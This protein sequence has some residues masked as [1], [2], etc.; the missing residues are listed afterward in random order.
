VRKLT[1]VTSKCSSGPF[2]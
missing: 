2:F 1:R